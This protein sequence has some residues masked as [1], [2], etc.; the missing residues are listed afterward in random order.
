MIPVCCICGKCADSYD[1][2]DWKYQE[3]CPEH[4]E[5][6]DS[7]STYMGAEKID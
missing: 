5:Q 1:D 3:F 7:I 6:F 4:A 2:S